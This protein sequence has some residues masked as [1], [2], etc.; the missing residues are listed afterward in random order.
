MVMMA[1]GG[2]QIFSLLV[3]LLGQQGH[4]SGGKS[5]TASQPFRKQQLPLQAALSLIW[6]CSD[7]FS[8]IQWTLGTGI[9]N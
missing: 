3:F 2:T 7:T 8:C 4:R 9:Y 5:G 1:H 6:A